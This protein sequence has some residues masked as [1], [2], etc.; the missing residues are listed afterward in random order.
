MSTTVPMLKNVIWQDVPDE[1]LKAF[2]VDEY[3]S[4]TEAGWCPQP[5]SQ[6]AF[7]ACPVFEALYEG[8]R[9]PGKTDTLLMDFAQHVGRGFGQDWRGI[10]FRRTYPELKDVIAKSEKWFR[11]MF[12]QATFNRSEH[13]WQWP[14]GEVLFFRHFLRESDYWSYHGHAYPWIAWEELTT[15]PDLNGYKKMMSCSRSTRTGMPR[16][17]RATSNPY[18]PGHNAVKLRFSLPIPKGHI[19]GPIIDDDVDEEGNVLPERVAIHGHLSENKILLHADPTYLSRVIAA[20][21]NDAERRAWRDGDWDIVSGGMFDDIWIMHRDTIVV[22]PFKI[23]HSWRIDRS[24]DWGS[25]APFSVGWWAE[26]DGTDARLADGRIISTVKGDLYRINEWYGWNGQP[27]EGTRMLATEISKGIIERELQW[28][29]HDRVKKGVADSSIFDD[30]NDNCIERDMRKTVR[31]DGV[32]YKGVPWNPADK[33]PGSRKQGWQLMRE[34]F[35]NTGRPDGLPREKPGMFIF[36]TCNQFLRTIPGLARDEKD[37]DDVDTA[38]EDHIAD[39]ARYRARQEK[40]IVKTT[41][42]VYA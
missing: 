7:L 40:R 33:R 19:V 30:E 17:Y 35:E 27:N 10:L 1:G 18:G 13:F 41:G 36:N 2:H 21:R 11:L 37:P 15:W 42:G 16:K 26:S 31:I 24:F 38:A 14:T 23:P 3:G 34:M 32:E 9:G 12:P 39:E 25:S 29:I 5:G 6:A 20:A 22:E 4:A 8:T 28:G